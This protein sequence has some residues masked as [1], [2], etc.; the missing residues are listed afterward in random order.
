MMLRPL[1]AIV[2]SAALLAACNMDSS[3]ALEN[4]T[5]GLKD[6]GSEVVPAQQAL[7]QADLAGVDLETMNE[8]EFSKVINP[9]P[10]CSFAYTGTGNPVLV[11]APAR[12]VVRGVIKL[13]GR[14]VEVTSPTAAL[15]AE[16]ADGARFQSDGIAVAVQPRGEG[17]RLDTG[18]LRRE[19]DALFKL[20]Q[21]LEVG[22]GGFYTCAEQGLPNVE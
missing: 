8:A 5:T 10:H 21:G 12:D 7:L 2:F 17:D 13:N 9:G 6:T 4:A 1:S 3:P 22:Y 11:A 14:L 16:L 19:A 20:K 15:F 18:V